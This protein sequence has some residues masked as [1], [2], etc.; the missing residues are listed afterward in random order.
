M[1]DTTRY[2]DDGTVFD[3]ATIPGY[4]Y[5]VRA[6]VDCYY[7]VHGIENAEPDPRWPGAPAIHPGAVI[8][9]AHTSYDA[10]HRQALAEPS[11]GWAACGLCGALVG[12][13]RFAMDVFAP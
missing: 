11:F 7:T 2:T 3:V 5:T 12:G 8:G 4:A 9:D 10:D 6:C 1:S 13:D